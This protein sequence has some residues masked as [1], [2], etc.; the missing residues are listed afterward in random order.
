MNTFIVFLRGVMP[1][2]KNRV[3][4]ARLRAE[5]SNAAFGNVRTYIQSG[6]ALVDT[7]L[8]ASAVESRIRE[9]IR[10]KIGT[11]LSIVAR[12]PAQIEKVLKDNP[13]GTQESERT[14]YTFFRTVPDAA[15]VASLSSQDFTPDK[16]AFS[17]TGAFVFVP[18]AYAR[19]KLSNNNLE[20]KLGVSATTRNGNTL[21][22][23]LALAARPT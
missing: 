3:P 8:D 18:G 6:N 22:A 21:R 16:I 13:F 12:T 10:D 23:L 1:T 11:E 9:V 15:K 2:G 19:S 4:M 20:R 5:L 14:F 7:D 17:E